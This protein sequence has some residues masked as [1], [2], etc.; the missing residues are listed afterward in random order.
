MLTRAIELEPELVVAHY[1]LGRI[2]DTQGRF[3]DATAAFK[4]ALQLNP[5]FTKAHYYMGVSYNKTKKY[6]EAIRQQNSE[7]E[8]KKTVESWIHEFKEVPPSNL[9]QAVSS[10]YPSLNSLRMPAIAHRTTLDNF[11][12]SEPFV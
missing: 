5:G 11:R 7:S 10:A 2:Y 1:N 8:I 9:R 6:A 4:Q 3:G 12:S